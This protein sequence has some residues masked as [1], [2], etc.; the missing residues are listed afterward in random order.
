MLEGIKGYN[1]SKWVEHFYVNYVP[2]VEG[3]LTH[4]WSDIKPLSEEARFE[5]IRHSSLLPKAIGV[6]PFDDDFSFDVS[7]EQFKTD[8]KQGIY[9]QYTLDG[10]LLNNMFM[11]P[12]IQNKVDK[13]IM[14]TFKNTFEIPEYILTRYQPNELCVISSNIMYKKADTLNFSKK[15]IEENFGVGY[16][17]GS[18]VQFD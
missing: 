9:N 6:N 16:E 7:I 1:D 5:K 13:L 3:Q 10:G 15:F 2:V 11:E 17:M 4:G 18:K 14:I 12:F 8:L